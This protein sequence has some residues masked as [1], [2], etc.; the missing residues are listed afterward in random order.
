[1]RRPVLING[2]YLFGRYFK[3]YK[4]FRRDL[5]GPIEKTYII[6][7]FSLYL[8]YFFFILTNL[9]KLTENR[10]KIVI[11]YN[12]KFKYVL[13][14]RDHKNRDIFKLKLLKKAAIAFNRFM[15]LS[16]DAERFEFF[17]YVEIFRK[18]FGKNYKYDST[19]RGYDYDNEKEKFKRIFKNFYYKAQNGFT[20][21]GVRLIHLYVLRCMKNAKII[22]TISDGIDY[23]SYKLFSFIRPRNWREISQK[24][25]RI[26]AK[27]LHLPEFFKVVT[28]ST[29]C[30]ILDICIPNSYDL[31][32]CNENPAKMYITKKN[33][34]I[35]D[36]SFTDED[37]E[38]NDE[39][40][41]EDVFNLFEVI[42][43]NYKFKNFDLERFSV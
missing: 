3:Q 9:E 39:I 35:F 31:F 30:P 27:K 29:L 11:Y 28:R 34:I 18:I 38:T 12:I 15:F 13:T 23:N 14:K 42:K 25:R 40:D 24:E 8:D 1:M 10:R 4:K 26:N 22:L 43:E 16:S 19:E 7:P 41:R 33:N 20:D 37:F 2:T 32:L 36:D 6:N 5:I 17:E 21:R